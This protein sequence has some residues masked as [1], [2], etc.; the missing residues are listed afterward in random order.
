MV[1]TDKTHVEAD[2][3]STVR[4][5]AKNYAI[6]SSEMRHLLGDDTPYKWDSYLAGKAIADALRQVEI[7]VNGVAGGIKFYVTDVKAAAAA[8]VLR[9]F[10]IEF[11]ALR[12]ET[13]NERLNAAGEGREGLEE[14]AI[15][16]D[17]HAKQLLARLTRPS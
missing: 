15:V 11:S 6:S 2:P 10:G 7:D 14:L 1:A 8:D 4:E 3:D 16:G 5:V 12:P 9:G 13:F 17:A